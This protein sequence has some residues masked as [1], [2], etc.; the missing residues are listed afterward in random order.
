[1][2]DD[3]D[4]GFYLKRARAFEALDESGAASGP[5]CNAAGL[6]KVALVKTGGIRFLCHQQSSLAPRAV[7]AFKCLVHIQQIFFA[8]HQVFELNINT[9]L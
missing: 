3:Y 8:G 5:L 7:P 2:T 1:M 9:K 4:A 6:L